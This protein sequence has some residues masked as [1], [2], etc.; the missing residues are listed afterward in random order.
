MCQPC[1]RTPVHHVPG[2]D[3]PP[4]RGILH[5]SLKTVE[6]A[7]ADLGALR[8]AV[9]CAFA[10]LATGEV[11]ALPK[12]NLDLGVGHFFQAMVAAD[13]RT[14]LAAVKWVAVAPVDGA[15]AIRSHI[16]LSRRSTG[17][18]LATMDADLITAARTAAMSAIAALH[19][20]RPDSASM[21]FIGCDSSSDNTSISVLPFFSSAL[22]T[23]SLAICSDA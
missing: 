6:E 1:P 2:P 23:V 4:G 20:A 18:L 8:D 17:A 13:S 5:I 3:T 22:N 7:C 15:T 19:L 12:A 10:G 11:K 21:A 14:D 9:R 16:M